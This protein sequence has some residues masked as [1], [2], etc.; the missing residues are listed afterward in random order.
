MGA[1]AA[2]SPDAGEDGL[3]LGEAFPGAGAGFGGS[4]LYSRASPESIYSRID[5][6]VAV[7]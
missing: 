2:E 4:G 5:P 7:V 6:N 3:D 1:G